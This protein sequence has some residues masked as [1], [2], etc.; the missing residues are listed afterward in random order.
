MS[1]ATRSRIDIYIPSVF[2]A[3]LL[4]I[5][6]IEI[7]AWTS[8]ATGSVENP[9][10]EQI[11]PNTYRIEFQPTGHLG[12]VEVFAS[13]RPDRIDSETPVGVLRD[14]T[15]NISVPR[16]SRPYLFPPK[17]RISLPDPV[18]DFREK[19]FGLLLTVP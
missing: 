7:D 5:A 18:P 17:C 15:G 12:A 19:S 2:V 3:V 9:T 8:V 11:G 14:A 4:A 10:C 13:S 6:G 1:L 16:S